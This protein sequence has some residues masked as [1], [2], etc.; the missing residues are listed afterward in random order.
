VEGKVKRRREE[1]GREGEEKG[2][3]GKRRAEGSE[4]AERSG[5]SKHRRFAAMGW[6]R[7]RRRAPVPT[8]STGDVFTLGDAPEVYPQ[9]ASKGGPRLFPVEAQPVERAAMAEESQ[10]QPSCFEIRVLTRPA[11]RRRMW[12]IEDGILNRETGLGG[13]LPPV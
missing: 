5:G 12:T 11:H 9:D 10:V 8:S 1:K 6:K 2:R 4:D 3:E 13:R 7:R